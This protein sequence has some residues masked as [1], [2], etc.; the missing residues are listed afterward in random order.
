MLKPRKFRKKPEF[1]TAVQW[2]EHGDHPDVIHYSERIHQ[3]SS[4]SSPLNEHGL[5]KTSIGLPL[6]VCPG[7]WIITNKNRK[8]FTC[9][10][11]AFERQ[12][13]EVYEKRWPYFGES[14]TDKKRR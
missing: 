5:M 1:I 6:M 2:K 7:T 11:E 4:C 12:Y 9:N 13:E 8:V 14:I 10:P 3:C